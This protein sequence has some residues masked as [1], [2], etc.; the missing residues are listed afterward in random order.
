M[1]NV[2]HGWEQRDMQLKISPGPSVEAERGEE[3]AFQLVW[4]AE[5]NKCLVWTETEVA[6]PS[7]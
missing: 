1:L 2:E 5:D 3:S 4:V 6:T 7:D